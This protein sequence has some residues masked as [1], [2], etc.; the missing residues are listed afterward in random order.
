[1][2]SLVE[3]GASPRASPVHFEATKRGLRVCVCY[4]RRL[5]D[6]F[7]YGLEYRYEALREALLALSFFRACQLHEQSHLVTKTNRQVNGF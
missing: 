5:T 4:Y 7:R 1:M 2:L 3:D 6:T